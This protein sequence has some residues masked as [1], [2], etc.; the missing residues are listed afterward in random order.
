MRY[1][2]Q[3]HT[4]TIAA[5][6]DGGML[7]D[8][9]AIRAGVLRATTTAPSDMS[10][11]R[12]SRS[13]SCGRRSAELPR[14]AAEQPPRRGRRAA[15]AAS[16]EAWSFTRGE[17]LPFALVDRDSIGGRRSCRPGDRPRRDR[18]DLPRRRASRPSRARRRRSTSRREGGTQ[19]L[20]E[21]VVYRAGYE[22]RSCCGRRPRHHRGHPARPQLGRRPDEAGARSA[23]R[24]RPSS[25]RCS[26]SPPRSTTATCVCSRRRRAC[27]SSWAR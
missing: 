12:R 24:S 1:V 23:P 16:I 27:R 26:T 2:G 10:S 25:T 6:G 3:E 22:A 5:P 13:C 14:R 7:A 17:R 9:D 21:P 18:H 11:T 4:L 15:P 8:A 20:G 19:M